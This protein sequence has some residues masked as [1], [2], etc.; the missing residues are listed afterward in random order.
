[1]NL[2]LLCP[3][4]SLKSAVNICKVDAKDFELYNQNHIKHLYT[5]LN[6]ESLLLYLLSI[7][8]GTHL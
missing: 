5:T 3:Q 2:K 1:M 8:K 7:I 4:T 6:I